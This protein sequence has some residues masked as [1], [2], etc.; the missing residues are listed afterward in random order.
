MPAPRKYP[1]DKW[2]SLSRL[3]LVRGKHF[4]CQPYAMAIQ[5]RLNAAKYRKRVRIEIAEDVLLVKILGN[6]RRKK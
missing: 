3:R 2:F 4:E 1:W 5:I 6:T